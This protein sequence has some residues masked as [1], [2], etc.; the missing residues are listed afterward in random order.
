MGDCFERLYNPFFRFFLPTMAYQDP[1]SQH[2]SYNNAPA[3]SEPQYGYA[4]PPMT[5]PPYDAGQQAAATTDSRPPFQHTH[6][7]SY[8]STIEKRNPRVSSFG[9]PPKYVML[10]FLF[11]RTVRSPGFAEILVSF[12]YGDTA[13]TGTYGLRYFAVNIP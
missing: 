1:Y 5:Y 11:P 2:Y 3:F 4:G 10:L 8:S 6:S 9:E 13:N 7:S 12:G